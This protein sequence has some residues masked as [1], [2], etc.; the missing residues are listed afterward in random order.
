MLDQ[1]RKQRQS[2]ALLVP[3]LIASDAVEAGS[4]RQTIVASAHL[5]VVGDV[6]RFSSAGNLGVEYY[7]VG[8]TTDTIILNAILPTGLNVGDTFDIWRYGYPLLGPSGEVVVSGTVIVTATD[9][10]IRD[11]DSATDSV[12][13]E[14]GDTFASAVQTGDAVAGTEQGPVVMVSD[15]AT[16]APFKTAKTLTKGSAAM[17]GSSAEIVAA[18]ARHY[19]DVFNPLTTM[20][21]VE[22]GAA[23]VVNQCYP[24]SP[25]GVRRFETAQ[26]L[27]GILTTGTGT[28]YYYAAT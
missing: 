24:I 6:L 4:G 26:Q 18:A 19:I 3:R 5:A 7:V 8:I 16:F 28:I 25:G 20:L 14:A 12:T 11:L 22:I 10:D 23:A 1:V 17:T 2:V 27:R 9:L 21:W 15:G 13:A